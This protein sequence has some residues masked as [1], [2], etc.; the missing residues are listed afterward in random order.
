[1]GCPARQAELRRD[2]VMVIAQAAAGATMPQPTWVTRSPSAHRTGVL[3]AALLCG[4]P[5]RIRAG[6]PVA[7]GLWLS[8]GW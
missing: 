4:W 7:A 1:V 8:S 6:W 3:L 5:W 2:A